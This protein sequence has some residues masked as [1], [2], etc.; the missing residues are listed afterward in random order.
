MDTFK[1]DTYICMLGRFCDKTTCMVPGMS[2]YNTK[3]ID[4]EL[5]I[6]R[7]MIEMNVVVVCWHEWTRDVD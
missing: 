7:V 4:Y 5:P 3:P 2:W 1:I 6:P